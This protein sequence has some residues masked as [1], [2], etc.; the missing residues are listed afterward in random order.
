MKPVDPQ[1]LNNA[2]SATISQLESEAGKTGTSDS[3]SSP[4]PCSAFTSRV[5]SDV[6]DYINAHYLENISLAALLT[7]EIMLG[8]AMLFNFD[9]RGADIVAVVL[10]FMVL[11][12]AVVA[13]LT[14]K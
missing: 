4:E 8:G 1:N 5:I 13:S 12:F 14:D 6:F 9:F 2:L 11:Y 7:M 10:S 3:A